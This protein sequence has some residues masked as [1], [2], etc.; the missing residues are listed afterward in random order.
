M[1]ER[2]SPVRKRLSEG[3]DFEPCIVLPIQ[4]FDVGVATGEQRLLFAMLEDAVHL[5]RRR[6]GRPSRRSSR[7]RQEIRAAKAWIAADDPTFP[8]SFVSVCAA[9]GLDPAAVR[10]ELRRAAATAARA[11]L[12][13]TEDVSTPRAVHG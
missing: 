12:A 1:T 10:R 5:L 13:T 4:F 9:L 2:R 6:P 8:F 11:T 7:D 3:R